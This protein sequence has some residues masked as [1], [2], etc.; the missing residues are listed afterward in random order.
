M[1]LFY[2]IMAF[3]EGVYIMS[4]ITLSK[5]NAGLDLLK[6]FSTFLV[7]ILHLLGAGGI[8]S[9][10]EPLS[11]NYNITWLLETIAYNSVNI[12]CITTGFVYAKTQN[13]R[14]NKLFNLWGAV[15]FY[16]VIFA[17]VFFLSGKIV[18]AEAI[19]NS[20]PVTNKNHWYFSAYVCL[21]LFI[22][23]INKMLCTL[24]KKQHVTLILIG[25]VLFCCHY[26]A[27]GILQTDI[28]V[29]K[30]GYSPLWLLYLYFIGS[31]ISLHGENLKKI[32]Q[33]TLLIIFVAC[34]LL[35]WGIKMIFV[36]IGTD[37]T[38]KLSGMIVSYP[39]PPMVVSSVTLFL[40]FI[41]LKVKESKFIQT[42]SAT[43]FF[44]YIL[45]T[46]PLFYFNILSDSLVFISDK[47]WYILIFS[48]L[49]IAIAIYLICTIIDILRQKLFAIIH[50]NKLYN[51]I[52]KY[53]SKIFS[54]VRNYISG[55]A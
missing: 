22:P 2:V 55:K 8:L 20:M 33:S 40:I 49:G 4:N 53:L 3:R 18:F 21:W 14:W 47:P 19:Y 35:A 6:I 31:Y 7:V 50:I 52:I 12:F 43:A 17:G 10:V 28:Y 39:S 45:H 29:L 41:N 23:Y 30:S 1:F 36:F 38:D 25:F 5:R 37:F 24:S 34:N 32:K 46:N 54:S 9:S 13:H 26:F 15:F 27:Y 11:A 51:F 16:S 48:V 44:V 42:L